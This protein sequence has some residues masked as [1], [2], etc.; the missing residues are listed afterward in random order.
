M[1]VNPTDIIREPIK[2]VADILS[3]EMGLKDGQLML[4]NEQWTIPQTEG[5]YVALSYLGPGEI[6]GNNNFAVSDG[7]GP[8]D[9]MTEI[10]QVTVLHRIQID[11]MSFGPE[12]RLRKEEIPMALDSIY[13][14]QKMEQYQMGIMRSPTPF[15]DASS[16]EE[17]KRLNR[18]VTS[19][20]INALFSKSKAAP[21]FKTFQTPEV[22]T[23]A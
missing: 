16:L 2:V 19:V 20:G 4:I 10:Q 5:L 11:I 12:A 1:T 8:N 15:L 22:H 17:T 21:Y 7:D 9:G 13:A 18:F 23:N 14:Q 3:T 6:I